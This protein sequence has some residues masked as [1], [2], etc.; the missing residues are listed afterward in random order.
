M[1]DLA[2]WLR[3]NVAGRPYSLRKVAAELAEYG[4]RALGGVPYA[5]AAVASM[6]AEVSRPFADLSAAA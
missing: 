4:Y 2:Q 1:V 3:R 5:A 6:L